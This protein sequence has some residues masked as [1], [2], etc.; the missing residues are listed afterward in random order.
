MSNL[1]DLKNAGELVVAC[2]VKRAKLMAKVAAV[3]VARAQAQ[4]DY[5]AI[6]ESLDA[7]TLSNL[8]AVAAGGA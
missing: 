6:R 3:D 1:Q 8:P 4:A 7:T 5:D 2:D